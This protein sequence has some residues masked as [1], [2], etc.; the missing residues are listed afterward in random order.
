[1]KIVSILILSLIFI[2]PIY[3][4]TSRIQLSIDILNEQG[5]LK[6]LNIAGFYP[7]VS[8]FEIEYYITYSQGMRFESRHD[9]W[10][11]EDNILYEVCFIT[12][13]NPNNVVRARILLNECEI[14][15]WQ[16]S[17][18]PIMRRIAFDNDFEHEEFRNKTYYLSVPFYRYNHNNEPPSIIIYID[19][20]ERLMWF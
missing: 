4:E 11:V 3:S 17:L 8:V 14:D 20:N 9:Y 1:M 10:W 15:L 12:N 7:F 2:F 19:G 6:E 16:E 13:D 5:F 18:G